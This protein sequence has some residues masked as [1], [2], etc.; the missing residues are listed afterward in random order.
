MERTFRLRAEGLDIYRPGFASESAAKKAEENL[1]LSLTN[2]QNTVEGGPFQNTLARTFV[3]YATNRLPY[4]KGAPQD[5]NLINR[6]LRAA[7]LPTIGIQAIDNR[8][9]QSEQFWHISLK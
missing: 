2:S 5:K 7:S 4:L 3:L 8:P 6:Y 1:R 9:I